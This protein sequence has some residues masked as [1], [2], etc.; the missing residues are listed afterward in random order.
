MCERLHTMRKQ[1]IQKLRRKHAAEMEVQ[2]SLPKLSLLEV[3]QPPPAI[4]A[5]LPPSAQMLR[6]V[7]M[8]QHRS[9][10]A[11]TPRV[12]HGP[13]KWEC[14]RCTFLNNGALSECE[15]CGRVRVVH[16]TNPLPA[17][18][19]PCSPPSPTTASDTTKLQALPQALT[20]SQ[21]KFPPKNNLKEDERRRWKEM[22][23]E[24]GR[25]SF[26]RRMPRT[27]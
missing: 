16:I 23:G 15:M 27:S 25:R 20:E 26:S 3:T 17:P 7:P 19:P 11:G 5:Q 2:A 18:S 9:G 21:P 6:S 10:D 4:L 13:A 14:G 22:E 12:T 24:D 1:E 8:A